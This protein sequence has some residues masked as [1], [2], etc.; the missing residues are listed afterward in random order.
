MA[1]DRIA[2]AGAD[3]V[4]RFDPR[5]NTPSKTEFGVEYERSHNWWCLVSVS[6]RAEP[7]VWPRQ[8]PTVSRIL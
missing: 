5:W 3:R 4:L 6:R 1:S 2:L 7:N 8:I